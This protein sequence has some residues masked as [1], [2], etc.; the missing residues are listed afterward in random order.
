MKALSPH[1]LLQ[2]WERGDRLY[3]LDQALLVLRAALPEGQ[4]EAIADWSLGR[5]NRALLELHV[6]CFNARLQA[7]AACA[8]CGEKMEFDLDTRVLLSMFEAATQQEETVEVNGRTFRLP[9]SRD[10]ARALQEADA[11][12]APMRI[13][14]ACCI[15]EAPVGWTEEDL[16]TIGEKLASADPIAEPRLSLTCPA[17]GE[18]QDETFDPVTF[19]W[20]E[21]QAV[22]KRLLREIHTLASAYGWSE[23]EI[24]SLSNFR[25]SQYVGMANT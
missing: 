21:L 6:F 18:T 16:N 22:A 1:D 17:C 3:P 7:W 25:R 13:L 5:R 23:G 19:V 14:Q 15:G 10:L 11:G 24:L 8:C 9:T 4:R 20:A 12:Q 2:L